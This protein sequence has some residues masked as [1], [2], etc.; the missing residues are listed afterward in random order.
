MDHV[1]TDEKPDGGAQITLLLR[2]AGAGDDRAIGEVFSRAHAELKRIARAQLS[3][4]RANH[5][6]TATALVN[7][8]FVKLVAHVPDNVEDRKHFYAIAARAMRQVLVS[9][10]ERREAIKRGGDQIRITLN[11][12]RHE[13]ACREAEILAVDRALVELHELDP[14]LAQIVEY[15]FFAGLSQDDI[16]SLLGV[17]PSTVGRNWRTARAWLRQ[18]LA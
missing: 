4:E 3:R 10:A 5:T 11:E 12:S 8:A 14:R 1:E 13:A 18:A 2:R 7:E 6:L 16:A 17:S 9:Y 15:R